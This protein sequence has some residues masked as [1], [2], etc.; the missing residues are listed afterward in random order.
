MPLKNIL[1]KVLLPLAGFL[2]A[3]VIIVGAVYAGGQG[4]LNNTLAS[5]VRINLAPFVGNT[6]KTNIRLASIGSPPYTFGLLHTFVGGTNDGALANGS[7]IFSGSKLYGVTFQGGSANKG[8][9][10]SVNTDGSGFQLLHSFQGGTSD[11]ANPVA[12]LAVSG[13]TLYG[14]TGSGGS[15]S[16][17]GAI[18]S[19]NT[20]GSGFQLLHAFVFGAPDGVF[21]SGSLIVFGST[22]YGMVH[23]GGNLSNGTIFSMNTNGSSFT[24][25]YTFAGAPSDGKFPLGSLILSGSTLYGMTNLGGVSN[26]GTIFSINTNGT[27]FTLLHSF[28]GGSSDGNSP[29]DS[30]TI[31]G[32]KLYGMTEN[33][34]SSDIGTIF[35]INTNGTGFQLLHT[36]LGGAGDGNLPFGSLTFSPPTTLYGVTGN[37]GSSSD[38]VL[39][40][41]NTDGTG[42]SL[43]HIFAGGASDGAAPEASLTLSGSTLYGMTAIG[44]SSNKGTIFSI[45]SAQPSPSP[46][47]TPNC[48][49][50]S[51]TNTPPYNASCIS[52]DANYNQNYWNNYFQYNPPSSSTPPQSSSPPSSS[53]PYSTLNT[54]ATFSSSCASSFANYSYWFYYYYYYFFWWWFYNPP[55]PAPTV[56]ISANPTSITAG[57]SATITWGSTNASSCTGSGFSTG[58]TTSGSVS[59]SPSTTTTY[60]VSCS[61]PGGSSSNSTLVTVAPSA[62]TAPPAGTGCINI[63]KETFDTKGNPITPVAQFNFYLVINGVRTLIGK[64]DSSGKLNIVSAPLGDNTVSEDVPDNWSQSSATPTGGIVNVKAGVCSTVV[65]K[66]VQKLNLAV[67]PCAYPTAT[68]KPDYNATCTA[69][70]PFYGFWY[71]YYYWKFWYNSPYIF[72]F[73]YYWYHIWYLYWYWWYYWW[74]YWFYFGNYW[75]YYW[76]LYYSALPAPTFINPS[77]ISFT[78]PTGIN[79]TTSGNI[80]Y[81]SS[82]TTY[83]ITAGTALNIPSG[84]KIFMPK[85]ISKTDPTGASFVPP[86]GSTITPEASVSY[87][88]PQGQTGTVPAGTTLPLVPGDPLT[89]SPKPANFIAPGGKD[90]ANPPAA[91]S[92]TALSATDLQSAFDDAKNLSTDPSLC[93]Y[94]PDWDT[95]LQEWVNPVRLQNTYSP[96]Q[97]KTFQEE[98]TALEY[99]WA[100]LCLG[101]QQPAQSTTTTTTSTLGCSGC[102]S[103]SC[104]AQTQ[105]FNGIP[106]YLFNYGG[107][108]QWPAQ[109]FRYGNMCTDPTAIDYLQGSVCEYRYSTCN[110]DRKCVPVEDATGSGETTT[111]GSG[112]CTS[113]SDCGETAGLCVTSVNYIYIIKGAGINYNPGLQDKT[114]GV[115]FYENGNSSNKMYAFD[116]R[117]NGNQL[118]GPLFYDL[119]PDLIANH[120]ALDGTDSRNNNE[121]HL[122]I[123]NPDDLLINKGIMDTSPTVGQNTCMQNNY[124]YPCTQSVI[125]RNPYN[126]FVYAQDENGLNKTCREYDNS[127]P[128]LAKS[129]ILTHDGASSTDQSV[130][131][132]NRQIYRM[133]I[134]PTMP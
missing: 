49:Y 67:N 18:Y 7:M 84:S 23:G 95:A 111:K 92:T 78:S 61:G 33:G 74:Y 1:T 97:T 47:P 65:F 98:A 10:F 42:Y 88:T 130:T 22:L 83:T 81:T 58:G 118:T 21:P 30:L 132:T 59:V 117:T 93:Q 16:N 104:S 27:S 124:V 6:T 13:S 71:Y 36:F 57:Q 87:T 94:M 123:T 101:Q 72:G 82:G 131:D 125:G 53:C 126:F 102:C 26:S 91:P 35:S 129:S 15:S 73:W 121:V 77:N 122:P 14:M 79:F 25:L 46:S 40:S 48:S 70:V 64:N 115:T 34:G 63:I 75:Y 96:S 4:M 20:D 29:T 134:F 44:G 52:S 108:F 114:N 17:A 113:D 109:Y 90:A 89:L 110:P 45:A 107:G 105:Q 5:L 28:T 106:L 60:S 86:T 11:G 116:N 69:T 54:T 55:T 2:L 120:L 38:G 112:N 85:G 39:F 80:T 119:S 31:I 103:G 41:I 68:T 50:P 100:N 76:Y 62:T 66:N 9:V 12:S 8:T 43:M 32:T 127:I 99:Q 51:A 19:I 56:T 3:F 128:D 24:V 37:G 133:D